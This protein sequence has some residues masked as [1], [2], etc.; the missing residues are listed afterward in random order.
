MEKIIAIDETSF[1]TKERSWGG[2]EGYQ[3]A[4]DKQIIKMGISGGQSCCENFGYFMSNDNLSDFIGESITSIKV[5]DTALNIKDLEEEHLDVEECMFVNFE[6]TNG[7]LQ[8]VAYNSHNGYYGH[9]A[10]IISE[11]ITG[12]TSL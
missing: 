6:T 2:Y 5:V 3:I 12:S 9:D 10:V 8:F 1:S 4:T 11:Q 7:T